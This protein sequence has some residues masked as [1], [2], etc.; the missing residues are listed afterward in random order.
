MV[1]YIFASICIL[2]MVF[3]GNV[4]RKNRNDGN[5]LSNATFEQEK[6]Y[7][8]KI[9]VIKSHFCSDN[10][11]NDKVSAI[12]GDN[13]QLGFCLCLFD[14][15]SQFLLLYK[16][17][18]K[19]KDIYSNETCRLNQISSSQF[20]KFI[21]KSEENIFTGIKTKI[22]IQELLSLYLFFEFTKTHKIYFLKSYLNH[23]SQKSHC[24]KYYVLLNRKIFNKSDDFYLLKN[25]FLEEYFV[26]CLIK[27]EEEVTSSV[28]ISE[29]FYWGQFC[30]FML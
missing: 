9:P 28:Y 12:F 20:E 6:S 21:Q 17:F 8:D 25:T 2:V 4:L 10:C 11:T 27:R 19:Q 7:N 30:F 24:K 3:M 14:E 15:K 18:P 22:E 23:L 1:F 5:I 16:S 13:I 26:T 29:Y